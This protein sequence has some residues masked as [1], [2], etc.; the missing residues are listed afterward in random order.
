MT[1]L[2]SLAHA[3]VGIGLTLIVAS[4]AVMLRRRTR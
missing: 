3:L 1:A 4:L 2:T